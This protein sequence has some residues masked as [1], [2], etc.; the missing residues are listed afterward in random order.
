M[1]K[2]ARMGGRREVIRASGALVFG[3][4]VGGGFVGF[5]L[6]WGGGE[7]EDCLCRAT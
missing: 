7:V 3:E 1:R 6:V 4:G 5:S 2:A